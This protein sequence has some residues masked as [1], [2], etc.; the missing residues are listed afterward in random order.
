MRK[1]GLLLPDWADTAA[2]IFSGRANA[3]VMNVE[4]H[5]DESI[6]GYFWLLD[7][8]GVVT[9]R[10]V[11]CHTA[12]SWPLSEN[13]PHRLR[14]TLGRTS[15]QVLRKTL[16]MRF[17]RQLICSALFGSGRIVSRELMTTSEQWLLPRTQQC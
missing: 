2:M 7:D 3:A 17:R 11:R 5:A 8:E 16:T 1:R 4:S 9:V 14:K 13:S 12:E 10:P 6:A 15:A